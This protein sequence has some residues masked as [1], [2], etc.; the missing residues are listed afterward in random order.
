VTSGIGLVRSARSSTARISSVY[1]HG[2]ELEKRG[3]KDGEWV[4]HWLCKPCTTQGRL[5]PWRLHLHGVV[6]GILRVT[7]IASIH[8]V[9]YHQRPPAGAV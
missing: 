4:K 7:D 6:H 5:K 1:L 3:R 2:I 9:S 8:Q